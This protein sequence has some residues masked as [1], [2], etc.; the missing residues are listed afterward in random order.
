MYH[1]VG[2][3]YTIPSFLDFEA[4]NSI[5]RHL[6]SI[7]LDRECEIELY[8]YATPAFSISVPKVRS[9]I[10]VGQQKHH[11]AETDVWIVHHLI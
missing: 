7:C 9:I 3:S 5:K 10:E 1:H 6:R 11:P 2:L 4:S 8:L